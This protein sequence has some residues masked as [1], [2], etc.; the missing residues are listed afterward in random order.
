MNEMFLLKMGEIVLKGLNR[1]SFEGKLHSNLSRR[2][3]PY[4]KFKIPSR[5]LRESADGW[6][7]P[8]PRW[9]LM[10]TIPITP[11]MW[12]CGRSVPLSMVPQSPVPV[13]C[14]WAWAEKRRCCCPAVSTAR[15]P[16]I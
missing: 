11:S 3:K 1:A 15:L 5:F 13:D 4:G 2:L 12:R 9:Q 10:S 8:I 7:K 6:R 14:R 16:V